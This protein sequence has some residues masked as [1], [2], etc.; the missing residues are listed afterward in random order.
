VTIPW[1]IFRANLPHKLWHL[2]KGG[3]VIDSGICLGPCGDWGRQRANRAAEEL[4]VHIERRNH[5]ARSVLL[6]E[7]CDGP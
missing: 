7:P 6:A 4:V 2:E 3:Q 1:T 5:T